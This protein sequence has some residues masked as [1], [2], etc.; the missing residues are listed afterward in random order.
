MKVTSNL[1]MR[2]FLS[3]PAALSMMYEVPLP[4]DSESLSRNRT[5]E[6]RSI[7]QDKT[8]HRLFFFGRRRSSNL[9]SKLSTQR[10]SLTFLGLRF[11]YTARCSNSAAGRSTTTYYIGSSI[12]SNSRAAVVSENQRIDFHPRSDSLLRKTPKTPGN[13]IA[14]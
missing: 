12:T 3:L 7:A 6:G 8:T 10:K 5:R 14:G 1:V 2:F 11:C 9:W 13:N 4:T